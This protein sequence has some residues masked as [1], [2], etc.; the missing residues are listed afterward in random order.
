MWKMILRNYRTYTLIH[1]E[2]LKLKV[3]KVVWQRGTMT[4]ENTN[5]ELRS[6]EILK[7]KANGA[8]NLYYD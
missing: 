5:F 4:E 3:S 1:N 2:Y 6:C 8:D 7:T